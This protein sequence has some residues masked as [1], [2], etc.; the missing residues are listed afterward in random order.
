MQPRGRWW[1]ID[2]L[3]GLFSLPGHPLRLGASPYAACNRLL[4]HVREISAGGE[5]KRVGTGGGGGGKSSHN[6]E[7]LRRDMEVM[8]FSQTWPLISPSYPHFRSAADKHPFWSTPL[9]RLHVD[10]GWLKPP[11]CPNNTTAITLAASEGAR[12]LSK[13]CANFTRHKEALAR[14]H[15]F[16]RRLCQKMTT[17]CYSIKAHKKTKESWKISHLFACNR[18]YTHTHTHTKY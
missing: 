17:I 15:D 18:L 4:R 1:V 11:R 14:R 10:R 5:G 8:V 9:V 16:R 7:W 2:M 3:L 13:R 12:S 6:G